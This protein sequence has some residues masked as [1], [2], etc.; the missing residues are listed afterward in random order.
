MVAVH[1]R[2]IRVEEDGQ[3]PQKGAIMNWTE[4]PWL[5]LDT[6]TTGPDPH[7]ARL[8]TAALVLRP[9]GAGDQQPEL[10]DAGTAGSHPRIGGRTGTRQRD[11]SAARLRTWLADPGVPIPAGATAI[12]GISTQTARRDGRPIVEV[13]DELATALV[14][15]WQQ[16]FPVVVFNAPFDLTLINAEL[17]RHQLGSL[18]ERLGTAPAPVID[19]LVLDHGLDRYRRGK[20]TLAAMTSVYGVPLAE[21]AHT[22]EVDVDMMLGVL[23]AMAA[24]FPQTASMD[25]AALHDFQID[26]HRTWADSFGSWLASRGRP[27]TISRSWP[28]EEP[29]AELASHGGPRSID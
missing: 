25:A 1:S 14:D 9:D 28:Q 11:S 27:D 19:P 18:E 23:A 24:K 15:H 6:E 13:L 2:G 7:T 20:R 10:G 21:N 8:V 5:G 29:A 26:N 22:A 4:A 16:G 17:R 12:H 3:Q